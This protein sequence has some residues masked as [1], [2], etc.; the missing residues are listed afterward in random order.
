MNFPSKICIGEN[1][2]DLWLAFYDNI[3]DE[4]ILCEMSGLLS[5]AEK[6]Q[7]MLFYCASD[8]KRYLVT[9]AMVRAVLS[10]YTGVKPSDWEFTT[11][12]YGRPEVSN[13]LGNGCAISGIVF[14]VSHT[15]GLIALAIGID[16]EL[17]V[18]VENIAIADIC[19]DLGNRF[20]SKE[21]V[22]ELGKVSHERKLRRFFEYWTFKESYIKARGMG[23]SIPLDKFTIL[24]PSESS[25]GIS[26]DAALHDDASRWGLRQYWP[27]EDYVLA[28]CAET[29]GKS[30]I[31]VRA[32]ELI[33]V[34]EYK[35]Y[36]VAP[37]RSGVDVG[38]TLDNSAG[39]T[40]FN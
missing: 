12:A 25:V 3:V 39:L 24:F 18:D 1:D 33:S 11:N 16:R 30:A 32:R 6:R 5:A 40:T 38:N 37:G 17:G 2:V 31:T 34:H 9:R 19:P 10:R 26:I 7:Q 15:D 14:N 22:A 8:R 13:I 23:L 29:R 28:I 36:A 20:F 21:E 27:G 35:N 4:A